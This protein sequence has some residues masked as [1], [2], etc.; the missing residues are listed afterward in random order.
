[1]EDGVWLLEQVN[2]QPRPV[3]VIGISG[4]DA[5]QQPRLAAAAFVRKFLKPLDFNQICADIVAVLR[6]PP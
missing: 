4:Y 6:S 2:Q 5:Q 1:M 3:P